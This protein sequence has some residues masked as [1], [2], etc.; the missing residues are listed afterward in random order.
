MAVLDGDDRP[1]ALDRRP[2]VRAVA[3]RLRLAGLC[4]SYGLSLVTVFGIGSVGAFLVLTWPLLRTIV[5]SYL[6]A[7][8]IVR[9]VLLLGRIVLAP[10]AWSLHEPERYRLLP[11]PTASACFWHRRLT[12]F[13][14]FTTVAWLT[15]GLLGPLGFPPNR[16]IAATSSAPAS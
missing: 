14:G 15:V 6:I 5:L 2:P 16:R 8:L 11:M 4:L 9:L 7:V 10:G 13:F 12:L 1:A 3:E